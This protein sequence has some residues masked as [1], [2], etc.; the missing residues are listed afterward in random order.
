MKDNYTEEITEFLETAEK[1][2]NKKDRSD[3]IEDCK[4]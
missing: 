2:E 1:V 4:E 3:L